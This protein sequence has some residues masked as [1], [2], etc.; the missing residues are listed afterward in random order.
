MSLYCGTGTMGLS[1][2]IG[3]LPLF[4]DTVE[5]LEPTR[6]EV[7]LSY[8]TSYPNQLHDSVQMRSLVEIKPNLF[9]R[10]QHCDDDDPVSLT[11]LARE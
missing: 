9:V 5:S 1:S 10:R 6:E 4:D 3:P 8:W 7:G 11:W 2:R